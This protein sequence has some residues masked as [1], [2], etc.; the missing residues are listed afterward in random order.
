MSR[1]ILEA[2]DQLPDIEHFSRKALNS[3]V[4][5]HLER[6]TPYGKVLQEVSLPTT[7]GSHSRAS[8]YAILTTRI[9]A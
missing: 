3:D 8:T 7:N 1:L 2:A 4:D 9:N 6:P 5:D